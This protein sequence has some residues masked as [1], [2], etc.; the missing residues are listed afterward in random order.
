[1]ANCTEGQLKYF[2]DLCEQKS[3]TPPAECAE[4]SKEQMSSIIQKTLA[5]R[6]KVK[7]SAKQI[8]LIC[9]ISERLE[10]EKP[11]DEI[12][13]KLTGGKKGTAS[14]LIE[15]LLQQE[16]ETAHLLPISKEQSAYIADM[17]ACPDVAVSEI[18]IPDRISTSETLWRKPNKDEILMAISSLKRGEANKFINKYRV[19]FFDWKKTRISDKQISLI[20][21]L[22]KY[23]EKLNGARTRTEEYATIEGKRIVTHTRTNEMEVTAYEK[24]DDVAIMQFNKANASKYIE[25]LQYELGNKQLTASTFDKDEEFTFEFLRNPIDD[26]AAQAEAYEDIVHRLYAMIGQVA[27]DEVLN[28]TKGD[29]FK[30]LIE[31][32]LE[33]QVA[34]EETILSIC[35][36][37]KFAANIVASVLTP[38]NESS[39]SFLASLV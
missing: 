1:M 20:R 32:I 11:S 2:K 36:G 9:S 23:M 15:Q 31:L 28:D 38:N 25:Q 18:G 7:A 3:L 17:Y 5:Y 33:M 35:D 39:D 22:E 13:S 16:E 26:V 29:A 10:L 4:W 27:E 6:P 8:E 19:P 12:L 34:A 14:E 24:L 21:T 30:Q 37:C